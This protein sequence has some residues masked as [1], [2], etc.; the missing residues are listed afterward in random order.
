MTHNKPILSC[1]SLSYERGGR[2]L[3]SNLSFSLL[4]GGVVVLSG[5]NGSGKN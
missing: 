5:A 2:D 1:N 4:E 3:F